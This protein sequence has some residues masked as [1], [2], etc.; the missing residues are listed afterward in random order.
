MNIIEIGPERHLNI[1]SIQQVTFITTNAG[2][3]AEVILTDG[4]GLDLDQRPAE[5]LRSRINNEPT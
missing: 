2:L 5:E 4:T 1:A 3:H